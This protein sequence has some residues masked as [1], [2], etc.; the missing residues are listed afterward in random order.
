MK[1]DFSAEALAPDYIKTISP[2]IPSN[3]DPVLMKRFG[4]SRLHR[5]NNNENPFGPPESARRVLEDF[6]MGR[7]SIYP[8]GDSYFL[9][10]ALAERYHKSPEQF[11][12]GNG[13]NEAITCVIKAFCEQGD[14]IV[15]ADRTYATYEWVAE[16]SGL[17]ARLV[18]LNERY[19]FDPEKMLA[20][21]DERTK[22]IFICNPNNPTG[23]WW[24]EDKLRSFIESAGRRIIVVDEAYC[25]FV[26]Q[27]GFPDAMKLMEQYENVI[28]FRTFSKMYGLAGL[29]VG[30]LCGSAECIDV[31]RRAYV[32][33]SV[34]SLG[35]LAAQAAVEEPGDHVEK[36]LR[37]VSE[38]RSFLTSEFAR[39]GLES[40]TG[41]GI[42][43]MVR[44]P[45]P[46]TTM[47]RRLIKR[48][49]MVRT[50]TGFRFPNWIRVTYSTM[51]VMREFAE[52]LEQCLRP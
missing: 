48:G 36:T 24:N 39:L 21:L 23:T 11:L 17:E 22:I 13:S 20:A 9:K 25:E 1:A 10:Y 12:V 34:N 30:Y 14:N 37:M 4:V 38:A 3:P 43:C 8:S 45:C 6:N 50:M 26:R 7:T 32:V 44:M 31:V 19:E 52:A 51:D 35:Q 5:L 16:F 46:D 42:F 33:Y 15:T 40:Q 2:Y 47:Y 41:E 27:P 29:R 49:I 18:P 28:S